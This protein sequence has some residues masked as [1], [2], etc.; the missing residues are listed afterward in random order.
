[1]PVQ[2][3]RVTHCS[4]ELDVIACLQERRTQT[5]VGRAMPLT[6][7]CT[8]ND[9]VMAVGSHGCTAEGRK[10]RWSGRWLAWQCAS[11]VDVGGFQ[12]TAAACGKMAGHVRWE[13]IRFLM[14]TWNEW[15]GGKC[16]RGVWGSATGEGSL[17]CRQM[18]GWLAPAAACGA[19]RDKMRRCAFSLCSFKA[20]YSFSSSC[21]GDVG[22]ISGKRNLWCCCGQWEEGARLGIGQ[23]SHVD[24]EPACGAKQGLGGDETKSKGAEGA[25]GVMLHAGER[26]ER[27]MMRHAQHV[28]TEL[29]L[30]THR[31]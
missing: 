6:V 13:G 12:Q 27:H 22:H 15:E 17:C 1:M 8:S 3:P 14:Q 18:C 25:T 2:S 5:A 29:Q 4:I 16:A 10:G 28:H 21:R 26:Q 7:V 30:I 24:L 9:T 20:W 23:C 19:E 11:R 31:C